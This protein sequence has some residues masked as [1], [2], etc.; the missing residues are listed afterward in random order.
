M[1]TATFGLIVRLIGTRLPLL[2]VVVATTGCASMFLHGGRLGKKGTATT[3]ALAKWDVP[4]CH[5]HDGRSFPPPAGI[6]YFLM[7]GPAGE[8]LFEQ[9]SDG[10][11]AIITNRWNDTE[12]TH[13]Y[14]WVKS[15]GWEYI[16]SG[17]GQPGRRLVYVNGSENERPR[18]EPMAEC[19][20]V[21]VN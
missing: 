4:A 18:G 8:E 13:F 17:P 12:G 2:A 9:S 14:A 5:G 7:K 1:I 3:G 20:M 21:A 15:S 10:S 19:A 16:L 11:G 6:R